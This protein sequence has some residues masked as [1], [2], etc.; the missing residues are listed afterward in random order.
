VALAAPPPAA[1]DRRSPPTL[2]PTP[3]LFTIVDITR[4]PAETDRKPPLSMTA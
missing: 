3:V 1:P 2:V 4:P